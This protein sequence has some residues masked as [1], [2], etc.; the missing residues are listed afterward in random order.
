MDKRAAASVDAIRKALPFEPAGELLLLSIFGSQVKGT[1]TIQSDLDVLFVVRTEFLSFYKIIHDTIRGTP[2]GIKEVSILPR[3]TKTIRKSCNVYGSVEYSVLRE[4]DAIT[5]YRSA[6]FDV[7]LDTE[8]DYEYC[9]ERWLHLAE[10]TI[11]PK[12]RYLESKPGLNCFH[13]RNA[14]D[15]LLRTNLMSIKV[16]FPFTRKVRV[17]YEMLPPERRPPLELATIESWERYRE[18][19]DDDSRTEF[20]VQV[21][22]TM[23]KNVY[24]FTSKIIKTA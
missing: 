8:I 17:L 23:A 16:R 22:T 11:F 5:L 7:P 12:Q 24:E 19:R 13:M 1:E 6:D 4:N 15:Y 14:I 21:A 18:D 10:K 3:T 2:D 9:A 20:D